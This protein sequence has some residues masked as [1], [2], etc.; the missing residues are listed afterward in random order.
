MV[1]ELTEKDGMKMIQPFTRDEAL[2]VNA[3][4][5]ASGSIWIE[6]STED[7]KT[8]PVIEDEASTGQV[9]VKRD[10][11]DKVKDFSGLAYEYFASKRFEKTI[12]GLLA[13]THKVKDFPGR[14]TIL[15][16]SG[17]IPLVRAANI[18]DPFHSLHKRGRWKGQEILSALIHFANAHNIT[19]Y[20]LDPDTY[21]KYL[22]QL[23]GFAGGNILFDPIDATRA[24]LKISELHNLNRIVQSTGGV[25]LKGAKRFENFN[26]IMRRDLTYYYELS[27]YPKRKQADGK[28]HNIEV[29]VKRRGVKVR[30]RKGYSDYSEEQKKKLLFASASYNPGLFKQIQFEVQAIPFNQGK[31]KFILWMNIALPVKKIIHEN[32]EENTSKI[33]KLNIWIKEPNEER[34]F[35]GQIGIP[36]NLTSSFLEQIKKTE[37]LI[38]S[39]RTPELKLKKDQYQIIFAVFDPQMNEAGTWESSIT[40]PKFEKT[41]QRSIIN[42]ILGFLASNPEKR[43]NFFSISK[44]DGSLE[45][46][47]IKFLPSVINQFHRIQNAS[48]FLQMYLPQGK[49]T[50]SPRFT[51]SKNGG[52]SQRISGE[53]IAESW[54]KKTKVWSGIFNLGLRTLFHGDYVLLVE[55]PVSKEEPVLKKEVKL[56]KLRY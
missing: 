10:Y 26:H 22:A 16:I 51:I 41:E 48:V 23:P 20:A 40:L 9:Q 44:K 13:L 32:A 6:K 2:L 7:L 28:Y 25:S 12:N 30:F 15:L 35:T 54:D 56:T 49:I 19:F 11:A 55:I 47:Q 4:K 34:A 39:Y 5:K 46:G 43:K 38:Y 45:Y 37:Y 53:V 29:K 14:K 31:D 50:V 36:F 52:I 42:C 27:F 33:I 24:N 1:L 3:V 18:F 8:G 17:G 21:I